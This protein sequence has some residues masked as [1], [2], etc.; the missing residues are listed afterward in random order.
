M[1]SMIVV[2]GS[3]VDDQTRCMHYAGPL[4]VIAIRFAC[5]GKWYPCLHCH[6]ESS[7][8]SIVRW[9][10]EAGAEE[11]VICG[12]CRTTLSIDHYLAVDSCPTCGAGFNPGCALHHG[13]Y[14]TV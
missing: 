7:G 8:H 4:D 6:D 12:V 3:V 9:S 11:A 13:V 10:V 1:D 5:C 14:F 2:E